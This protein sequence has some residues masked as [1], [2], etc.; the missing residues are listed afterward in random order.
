MLNFALFIPNSFAQAGGPPKSNNAS[1]AALVT[2]VSKNYQTNLGQL[3][4]Y[5]KSI[6]WQME[7][8]PVIAATSISV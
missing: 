7:L 6:G 8:W 3:F 2:S 1:C 4:Q 5:L